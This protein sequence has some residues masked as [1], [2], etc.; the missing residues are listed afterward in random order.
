VKEQPISAGGRF[1]NI[2]MEYKMPDIFENLDAIRLP[3]GGA[4]AGVA[5][6]QVPPHVPVR[7][8]RRNEFD[9]TNP[10]PAMRVPT[11]V[12]VDPDDRDAVYLVPPTAMPALLGEARPV[13]LLP[14]IN[15]QGTLFLWPLPLPLDD[16]RRNDWHA[17]AREAAELAKTKWVRLA[18]DMSLGAYRVYTA[19]GELPKPVWP[20]Q[21]LNDLLRVA[22]RDR[23]IDGD[24]LAHPIVRR[25]RGRA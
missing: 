18:A 7:K 12:Y 13:M 9:M 24:G 1:V 8:P 25:L 11:M 14:T 5:V 15:T 2:V 3:P 23:V 20:E 21:S 4:I 16:G 6:Q 22:F 17:T 19:E 10:D